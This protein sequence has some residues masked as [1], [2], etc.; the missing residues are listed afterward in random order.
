MDKNITYALSSG[1][2][3]TSFNFSGIKS[4]SIKLNMYIHLVKQNKVTNWIYYGGKINTMRSDSL[5]TKSISA[6]PVT[7]SSS[8][9]GP[10][11]E[12]EKKKSQIYGFVAKLSHRRYRD[13]KA[14]VT[15]HLNTATK[16]HK[17]HHWILFYMKTPFWYAIKSITKSPVICYTKC[18]QYFNSLSRCI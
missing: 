18:L 3:K 2:S 15:K 4:G 10:L 11:I 16:R 1:Q 5:W 13:H 7:F 6:R 8:D 12:G 9:S 17:R 14:P